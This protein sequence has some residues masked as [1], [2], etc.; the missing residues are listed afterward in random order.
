MSAHDELLKIHT[1][2]HAPGDCPDTADDDTL[3]VRMLKELV[4]NWHDVCKQR[5]HYAEMDA[6]HI[7]SLGIKSAQLANAVVP[8]G[9]KLLKDTTI[10]ERSWP[11][12]SGH[13]NGNYYCECCV[14]LRQFTGH[15]RRVVC[16]VCAK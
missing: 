8:D 16:K 2:L 6:L 1:I 12:D 13:E 4:C 11:E 15:K 10:Q 14:C 5:D 7:E 9:Y 3:T